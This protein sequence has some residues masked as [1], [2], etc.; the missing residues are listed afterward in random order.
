MNQVA[1]AVAR[2]GAPVEE[3]RR[4]TPPRLRDEQLLGELVAEVILHPPALTGPQVPRPVVQAG[5]ELLDASLHPIHMIRQTED[6]TFA[7]AFVLHRSVEVE[8]A[9]DEVVL[10]E[11]GWLPLLGLPR[12]LDLPIDV[13]DLN[14]EVLPRP[15]GSHVREALGAAVVHLLRALLEARPSW[16]PAPG[17]DRLVSADDIAL[18]TL[19]AAAGAVCASGP[20]G[21][22]AA[23]RRALL[24][25]RLRDLGRP[26]SRIRRGR[27]DPVALDDLRWIVDDEIRSPAGGT[28]PAKGRAL[29]LLLGDVAASPAFLELLDFVYTRQLVVATVEPGCRDRLLRVDLPD[30]VAAPDSRHGQ[31]LRGALRSFKVG[32][33][34]FTARIRV[35]V[36]PRIGQYRLQVHGSPDGN[37]GATTAIG[38]V[39]AVEVDPP[40]MDAVIDELEACRALLLLAAD[41]LVDDQDD[42]DDSD[43]PVELRR[44]LAVLVHA[45]A[46]GRTVVG[47]LSDL[48]EATFAGTR[49]A[50]TRWGL[51]GA[52]ARY[53]S[54]PYRDDRPLRLRLGVLDAHRRLCATVDAARAI[55]ACL[56]ERP[57]AGRPATRRARAR[58][59]DVARAH[60]VRLGA[61]A[62][63]ARAAA[64]ANGTLAGWAADLNTR[65]SCED[66]PGGST[67]RVVVTPEPS[68][69]RPGAGGEVTLDVWAAL[70]DQAGRYS[71]TVFAIPI[72]TV[73]LLGIFGFLIFESPAWLW[74]YPVRAHV[75]PGGALDRQADALAAVMLLIP[76]FVAHQLRRTAASDVLGWLRRTPR[77]QSYTAVLASAVCA[78]FVATEAG[79]HADEGDVTR[80]LWAFRTSVA[81]FVL[82][83]AWASLA[84]ARRRF[85]RWETKGMERAVAGGRLPLR[86]RTHRFRRWRRGRPP[87]FSSPVVQRLR[88]LLRSRYPDVTFDLTTAPLVGSATSPGRRQEA[89]P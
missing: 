64:A 73:L 71:R 33:H 35:P 32:D 61:L 17:E 55:D 13:H 76:G 36:A 48:A 63:L 15:R 30:I 43:D 7:Q 31:V 39:A 25:R 66:P 29:E 84:C 88:P 38:V 65:L 26:R 75:G 51:G 62:G 77:Q 23:Q 56:A 89:R 18:W 8:V 45:A 72:C 1:E 37:G 68:T 86:T 53:R 58:G 54:F 78:M 21:P 5:L 69:G 87:E 83:C 40:V 85:T 27:D 41:R 10:G 14:G 24:D 28:F 79:A 49:D 6:L 2:E 12:P 52:R 3:A 50:L 80:V 74:T 22:H 81:T 67:A 9:T 47:Q 46:E 42:Q 4:G 34:N 60:Q 16:T 57:G 70:V 44:R 59:R 19:Q 82:W 11:R 20:G